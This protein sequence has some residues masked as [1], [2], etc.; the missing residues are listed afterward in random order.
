[1]KNVSR[2]DL[3]KA[4][5]SRE[6]SDH[7]GVFGHVLI[8]AGS[9]GMSGAAVMAVK[10]ALRSG[11]GLVTAAIVSSI[12]SVVAAAAPEAVTLALEETAGGSL[13]PEAVARLKKAARERRFTTIALG[14][15]LSVHP[16]TA[17]AV[18]SILANLD[19][20]AV[21][22]A[23]ALNIMALQDSGGINQLMAARTAPSVLTPH[24]GE[25]ARCLRVS[26]SEVGRDREGCATRLARQWKATV[27]LK[28]HR[29]VISDGRRSIFNG[30]GGSGLAKG[31][32]GDVLTGLIAGLWA[33]MISANRAA[34]DPVLAAALGAHLHGLA[35]EFAE[36]AKTPW[37]MTAADVIDR[38]PDAFKSL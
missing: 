5:V 12:Q 23:D 37:A 13:R 1:M 10:A 32:S 11:A 2:A 3:K 4:L 15:G 34:P 27:L 19:L 14:P 16:E 30:T 28:G 9:R 26:S 33:Q 36:K 35:G 6:P 25:M 29:T 22:D 17:K 24:P 21:I 7:K 8:V 18:L 20:P 38:F 31:G